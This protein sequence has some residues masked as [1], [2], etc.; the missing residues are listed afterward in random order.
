MS[1]QSQELDGLLNPYDGMEVTF[2]ESAVTPTPPLSG[3]SGDGPSQPAPQPRRRRG[4]VLGTKRGPYKRI[5]AETRKRILDV[6]KAGGDWRLAATANGIAVRTAYGYITKP[7]DYQSAPRGGAT[8]KKVD[9]SIVNKMVEYVEEN[10][11]ITLTDIGR[12]LQ[13]DTGVSLSVPTIHN[14]L[15]GRMYTMNKV[16]VEPMSMKSGKQGKGSVRTDGDE[17]K[18]PG[19]KHHLHG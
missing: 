13:N 9:A 11:L 5:A 12:K 17:G 6:Y 8:S 16:N 15:N 4:L 18:R 19:Q 1:E 2:D 7:D 3:A 14:H 10:P